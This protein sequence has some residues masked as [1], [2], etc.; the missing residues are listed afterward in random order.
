MRLRDILTEEEDQKVRDL[1][2][3]LLD[4]HNETERQMILDEINE[5]F[6]TAKQ[7]YYSNFRN[8][9]QAAFLET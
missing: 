4:A 5:V 1:K 6:E 8:E 9:E 3:E 2:M 7:R